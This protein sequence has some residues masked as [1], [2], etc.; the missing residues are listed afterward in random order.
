MEEATYAGGAEDRAGRALMAC[1][2]AVEGYA[3]CMAGRR[4][5]E[6]GT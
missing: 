5:R 1:M 6:R 3:A 2:G 4:P